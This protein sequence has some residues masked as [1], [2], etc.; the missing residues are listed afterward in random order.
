MTRRSG[1]PSAA[2]SHWSSRGSRGL[3]INIALA[4]LLVG[5]ASGLNGSTLS[6]FPRLPAAPDP[7]RSAAAGRH[8]LTAG[9][10]QI[11]RLGQCGRVHVCGH[12]EAHTSGKCCR[13]HWD[14]D[15]RVTAHGGDENG[16]LGPHRRTPLIAP[17]QASSEA[18][19]TASLPYRAKGLIR[20]PGKARLAGRLRC[21]C[22]R[23]AARRCSPG[24]CVPSP[25]RRTGSGPL[26][27]WWLRWPPA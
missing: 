5:A 4:D 22:E 19:Q 2:T 7:R 14:A 26:G 20:L 17:D 11:L 18:T 6:S 12:R 25:R 15:P 13:G 24:A 16:P 10:V 23:R 1:A 9:D 3:D 21:G 27:R 8:W